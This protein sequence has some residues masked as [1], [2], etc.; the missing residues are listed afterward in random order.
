[1]PQADL[2]GCGETWTCVHDSRNEPTAGGLQDKLCASPA[3]PFG[4]ANIGTAFEPVTRLTAQVQPFR[5]AA[6]VLWL[7]T[8]AF[9]QNVASGLV[10]FRVLASHDACQRNTLS[11][12]GDQK[13]VV[14][15][16][17]LFSV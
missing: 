14:G 3:C 9:D 6:D 8:G 2:P 11:R 16:H 15:E 1:M 7:E 5:S 17:A 13:H 12:V 4:N 10:D